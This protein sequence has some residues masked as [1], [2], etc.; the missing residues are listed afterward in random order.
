MICVRLLLQ[1]HDAGAYSLLA[2]NCSS[3]FVKCESPPEP[4]FTQR[5][6]PRFCCAFVLLLAVVQ[7]CCGSG[8]KGS[9][10]VQSGRFSWESAARVPACLAQA[11]DGHC[12]GT[13]L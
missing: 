3:G 10:G 9:F 5:V 2:L 7:N 11:L 1:R 4:L 8:V 13:A 6:Q 12:V